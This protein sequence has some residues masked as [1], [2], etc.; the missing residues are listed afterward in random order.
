MFR[1][2]LADD[3]DLTRRHLEHALCAGGYEPLPVASAA[4]ALELLDR[5]YVDMLLL[6]IAGD[7][8]RS[9]LE[10][11]RRAGSDLP[12]LVLSPLQSLAEK[13]RCFDLGADGVLPK[14]IDGEELLLHMSALLRRSRISAA[15]R[16]TVGHTIL[17]YDTFT[18]TCDGV[19][20]E[21]PHKEFLL[22]F[23]LLSYPGKIFTRH[24]LME[25]IWG[26]DTESAPH[27]VSVHINRLRKRFAKNPDFAIRTIRNLGYK[28]VKL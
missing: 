12:I 7:E 22:L 23:K 25:E 21:L 10:Q 8:G 1:I 13:R 6:A 24:Q 11:I 14:N 5:C 18:V 2:L 19:S 16:I 4:D 27:T 20:V 15:H 28:A 9:L 3:E 26:L 17:S